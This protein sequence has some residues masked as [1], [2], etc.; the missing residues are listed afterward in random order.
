MR[1][2]GWFAALMLCAGACGDDGGKQAQLTST[3]LQ[4]V[5]T[6][7]TSRDS[8]ASPTS[9]KPATSAEPATPVEST[10][11]AEA[12]SATSES[13]PSDS[14]PKESGDFCALHEEIAQLFGE[15]AQKRAADAQATWH[16]IELVVAQISEAAPPE[17]AADVAAGSQY[18]RE[19]G[20]ALVATNYDPILA[21][22]SMPA[23]PE[24]DEIEARIT[25]YLDTN[26]P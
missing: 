5:A 1:W 2:I 13:R 15:L 12:A 25:A 4:D 14:A 20:E 22:E 10:T 21:V 17:L 3:T 23:D 19:L 16:D 11:S 7:Q 18:Y 8:E 26:C 24:M 9:T 6:S